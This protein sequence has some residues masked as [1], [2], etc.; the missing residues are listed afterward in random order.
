MPS[1]LEFIARWV[2]HVPERYEVRVRDSGAN[3]MRRRVGW[4]RRGVRRA[5]V[6][7]EPPRR[8]GARGRLA[9]APRLDAP[10]TWW[11]TAWL[12]IGF[13]GCAAVSLRSALPGRATSGL[14][15]T[16]SR[17]SPLGFGVVL[18]A[19]VLTLGLT[20]AVRIC[21]SLLASFQRYPIR[22]NV[23][24]PERIEALMRN[25]LATRFPGSG[26]VPATLEYELLR[27][28]PIVLYMSHPC[29][30]AWIRSRWP[31][32]YV[33][34]AVRIEAIDHSRF[35]IRDFL[36]R[37]EI[38]ARPERVQQVFPEALIDELVLRARRVAHP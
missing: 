14:P 30:F 26:H 37:D 9:G 18:I 20:A 10:R 25:D 21:A 29:Y 7:R 11:T 1:A 17:S 22:K 3:A 24:P 15:A 27:R 36:S 8:R 6:S 23:P 4:R 13:A 2:D 33:E 28:R 34:G 12:M 5:G 38:L 32:G 16:P 35:E 31:Y 19:V